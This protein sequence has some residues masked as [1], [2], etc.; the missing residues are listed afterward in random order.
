MNQWCFPGAVRDLPHPTTII[1]VAEAVDIQS[2]SGGNDGGSGCGCSG[3]SARRGG[4][5]FLSTKKKIT[6]GRRRSV[7]ILNPK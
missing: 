5:F 1:A 7:P 6:R 2:Y 4:F 3:N